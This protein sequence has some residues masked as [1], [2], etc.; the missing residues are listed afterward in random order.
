[1]VVN[2]CGLPAV[3]GRPKRAWGTR[4]ADGVGGGEP[5]VEVGVRRSSV[6]LSRKRLLEE[7]GLVAELEVFELGAEGFGDE[8]GFFGGA[9]GRAGAEVDAVEAGPAGGVE[10][11]AEVGD[12]LR[13][14]GVGEL[15]EGLFVGRERDDDDVGGSGGC[16]LAGVGFHQ[17]TS[18]V[19][20]P[21]R[22]T[23]LGRG[24]GTA[25]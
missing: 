3:S 23:P 9:L 8:G 22:R 14:D 12:G 17:P 21:R 25:R 11:G 16:V 19:L 15:L 20:P 2:H 13:R 1:M 24:R 6:A 18:E 10:E 7:V 5:L 4:G